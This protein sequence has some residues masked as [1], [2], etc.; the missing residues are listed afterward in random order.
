[1]SSGRP[2]LLRDESIQNLAEELKNPVNRIWEDL[3]RTLIESLEAEPAKPGDTHFPRPK[4]DWEFGV[5]FEPT[6]QHFAG[7]YVW[8]DTTL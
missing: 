4:L 7:P 3:E 5:W 1:L 2:A 8:R 6:R